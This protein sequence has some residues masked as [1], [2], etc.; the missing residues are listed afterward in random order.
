MQM[1]HRWTFVPTLRK[2]TCAMELIHTIMIMYHYYVN[3]LQ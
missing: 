1:Y 2:L 3:L